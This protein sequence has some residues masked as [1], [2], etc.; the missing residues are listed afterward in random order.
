MSE[1]RGTKG[2]WFFD[3][4]KNAIT[5]EN[6]SGI[7]ATAWM[8]YKCE[9]IEERLEGESWLEMRERTKP[10]RIE[11]DVEQKANALLISKAPEMLEMLEELRG[12]F[13]KYSV[14][15]QSQFF[16]YKEPL[17]QLIKEATEL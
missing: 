15:F 4:T 17:E 16:K 1:F 10:I 2:K 7:L 12:I 6:V 9:D 14:D 5:S 13:D 11:K 8:T 3:K